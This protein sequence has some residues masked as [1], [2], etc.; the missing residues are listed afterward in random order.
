[1]LI[2]NTAPKVYPWA[3]RRSLL[4]L[5]IAGDLNVSFSDFRNVDF[6]RSR[7]IDRHRLRVNLRNEPI[8]IFIDI[9]TALEMEAEYAR[10]ARQLESL[11]AAITEAIE[12][13]DDEALAALAA[14]R[15]SPN[16]HE[17][18]LSGQEVADEFRRLYDEGI[19][20]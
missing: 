19:A 5:D 18:I 1:M 13:A 4:D 7:L 17:P 8:G 11:Q 12:R 14:G 20:G 15:M 3:M 6:I 9:P 10:V 2:D 16:D